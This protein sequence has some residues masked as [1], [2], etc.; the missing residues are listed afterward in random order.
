MSCKWGRYSS[1]T[2][3]ALY[4]LHG[5][6]VHNLEFQSS[7]SPRIQPEFKSYTISILKLSQVN[8]INK[9]L[10]NSNS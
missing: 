9:L 5:S 8:C 6:H 10:N 4:S 3:I 2:A 1:P 7:H